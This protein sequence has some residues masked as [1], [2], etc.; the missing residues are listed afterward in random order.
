MRTHGLKSGR[1]AVRSQ[2]TSN[3]MQCACLNKQAT[4]IQGPDDSIHRA[5]AQCEAEG[6]AGSPVHTDRVLDACKYARKCDC[7][8]VQVRAPSV[9]MLFCMLPGML[10]TLGNM[11]YHMRTRYVAAGRC[12]SAGK[13]LNKAQKQSRPLDNSCLQ[14]NPTLPASE[15]SQGLSA[16]AG[17]QIDQVP[18]AAQDAYLR[19]KQDR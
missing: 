6:V 19:L 15:S 3:V 12:S 7:G 8:R 18:V 4:I 16:Q 13:V 10:L 2:A 9:T 14:M 1:F 5:A 11:A 17:G